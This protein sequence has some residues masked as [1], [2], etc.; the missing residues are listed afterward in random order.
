MEI[1]LDFVLEDLRHAE[2]QATKA[3][4]DVKHAEQVE[5]ARQEVRQAKQRAAQA[6]LGVKRAK[7]RH[8]QL[9]L[10]TKQLKLKTK[11]LQLLIKQARQ[12]VESSSLFAFLEECH[13][14]S[15]AISF[16]T[17]MSKTYHGSIDPFG[18]LRPKRIIPWGAFPAFQQAIWKAIDDEDPEFSTHRAF[19]SKNQFEFIGNGAT[20]PIASESHLQSFQRETVDN[21]VQ[22]IL[23]EMNNNERLRQR[24]NI[25]GYVRSE[26]EDNNNNAFYIHVESDEQEVPLYAVEYQTPHVLSMSEIIAGLHVMNLDDDFIDNNGG[27]FDKH[28]TWVVAAVITQLFSNMVNIGV[29]YGYIYTGE[30]F[31]CLHITEDPSVVQYYLL[32]PNLDVTDGDEF[33]L[34]RTAVAHVLALTLNTMQASPPP[35]SWYDAAEQLDEWEIDYPDPLGHIPESDRENG[36]EQLH[37]F[38]RTGFLLKAT[39]NEAKGKSVPVLIGDFAPQVQ[40]WYHGQQMA[41]ILCKSSWGL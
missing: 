29:Q 7:S 13:K 19:A 27:S 23:V 14:L 6:K 16:Q 37:I 3:E 12:Q 28:A 33:R 17:N 5:E 9:V 10:E 18:R 41:H 4:L 2:Q 15:L 21:H 32:I 39:T 25:H 38:C 30:A 20:R 40:H 24:F 22:S 8:Q 31:I 36:F 26:H 34:Q 11:Q 35:Q 1:E